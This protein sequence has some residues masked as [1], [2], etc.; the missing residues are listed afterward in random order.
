MG[1][2]ACCIGVRVAVG[3]GVGSLLVLAVL[4]CAYDLGTKRGINAATT[5]Y[6]SFQPS[7]C[8]PTSPPKQ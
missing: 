3:V 6:N 2:A 7:M 4:R 8:P 1:P 5:C